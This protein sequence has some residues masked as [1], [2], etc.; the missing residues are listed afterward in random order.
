MEADPDHDRGEQVERLAEQAGLGLDAAHPPAENADA[1][2]HRGVGVG[3][4]QGVGEGD[5]PAALLA[6]GDHR[7]E[8]LEVHLVD[9]AH[10]RW[11]HPEA[12]EGLLRPTEQLVALAVALVLALDVRGIRLRGAEGVDLDGVVDDEVGGRQGVDPGGVA[13][14]PGHRRA[15]RGEVDDRGHAGEVLEEHP[16]GGE[17]PLPVV[18]AGAAPADEGLDVRLADVALAAVAEQILEEDL[19]RDGE[20][21]GVA[22]SEGR[23]PVEA[24]EVHPVDAAEGGACSESILRHGV[25][26]VSVRAT[27]HLRT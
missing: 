22:D 18:A 4:D 20:C 25:L 21:G 7:G 3:P 1:V 12:V 16:G 27:G 9:D 23:Q 19:H 13:S 6:E 11:H 8:V 5:A 17:G 10:P 14:R 2:D 24:V 15:H 26:L